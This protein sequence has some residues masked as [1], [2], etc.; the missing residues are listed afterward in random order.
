MTALNSADSPVYA[1]FGLAPNLKQALP[2]W[3][4]DVETPRTALTRTSSRQFG[5]R[6]GANDRSVAIR[7]QPRRLDHERYECFPA[8]AVVACRQSLDSDFD[9]RSSR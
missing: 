9:D 7:R 8:D 2:A 6:L 4:F 5:R 3:R 1:P